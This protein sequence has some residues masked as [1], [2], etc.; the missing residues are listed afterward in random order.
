MACLGPLAAVIAGGCARFGTLDTAGMP[1]VTDPSAAMLSEL[2]GPETLPGS[3]IGPS[4][5]AGDPIAMHWVL[6]LGLT[7]TAGPIA[8]SPDAVEWR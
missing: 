3:A 4:L 5:I 2:S 1:P 7:H 8:W 6:A